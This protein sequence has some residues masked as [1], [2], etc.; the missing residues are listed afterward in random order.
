MREWSLLMTTPEQPESRLDEL[1]EELKEVRL[2]IREAYS[3][4]SV[5]LDG[6]S[7]QRQSI[8]TLEA[9]EAKLTWDISEC[10]RDGPFGEVQIEGRDDYRY[11]TRSSA[12]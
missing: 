9:R 1:R 7:L 2:K 6:H 10:L 8:E 5:A 3:G 4:P 12:L 11:F